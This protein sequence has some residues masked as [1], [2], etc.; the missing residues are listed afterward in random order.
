M[1]LLH[2]YQYTR[3]LGTLRHPLTPLLR[4]LYLDGFAY[5]VGVVTLRLW[6][7]L[8]VRRSFINIVSVRLFVG[9]PR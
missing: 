8:T 9:S 2:A 3:Q 5:F 6:S 4:T 7:A 1:Q